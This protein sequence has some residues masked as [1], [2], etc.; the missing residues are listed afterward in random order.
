M[1]AMIWCPFPDRETARSIASVLLDEQLVACVNILG[2]VESHYLWAGKRHTGAEIGAL[3]KTRSPL[4]DRAVERLGALHPYDT[5]AIIGWHC[6]AA[7]GPTLDWLANLK[8]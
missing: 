3:I 1:T 4:L 6:D 7:A 8:P 5:P 2:E